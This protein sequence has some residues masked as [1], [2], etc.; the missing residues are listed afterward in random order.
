MDACCI[1]ELVPLYDNYAYSEPYNYR[2]FARRHEV[3]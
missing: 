2:I 3:C 1:Q